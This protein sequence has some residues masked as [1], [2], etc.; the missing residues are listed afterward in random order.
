MGR[1]EAWL[2]CLFAP[3]TV[4]IVSIIIY[5]DNLVKK[6]AVAGVVV[7]KERKLESAVSYNSLNSRCC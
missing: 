6:K 4:I 7:E 5:A 1:V 3:F 2:L